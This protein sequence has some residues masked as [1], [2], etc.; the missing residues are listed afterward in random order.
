MAHRPQRPFDSTSI[1][2]L[3]FASGCIGMTCSVLMSIFAPAD[4]T[5]LYMSTV[6]SVQNMA[7]MAFSALFGL[8]IGRNLPPN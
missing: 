3:V 1:A 5:P 7:S 8:L 4:P 2:K 6:Q